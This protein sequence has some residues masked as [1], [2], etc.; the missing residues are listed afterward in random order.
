VRGWLYLS[1]IL[2]R[3]C[4]STR[5]FLVTSYLSNYVYQSKRRYF[6][7]GIILV[8]FVSLYQTYRSICDWHEVLLSLSHQNRQH[9]FLLTVVT[10]GLKADTRTPSLVAL[11]FRN[12][13]VAWARIQPS[14][15]CGKALSFST[16]YLHKLSKYGL[17]PCRL[18][19]LIWGTYASTLTLQTQVKSVCATWLNNRFSLDIGSESDNY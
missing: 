10:K 5:H 18:P 8:P 17:I 2:V 19:F 6:R 14:Y 11:V 16:T 7:V 13:W 9:K 4:V 3:V 15:L 12:V 1:Y